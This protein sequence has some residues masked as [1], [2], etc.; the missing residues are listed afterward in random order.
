MNYKEMIAL[1]P[2]IENKKLKLSA[3]CGALVTCQEAGGVPAYV[4][5][6]SGFDMQV[7]VALGG[8]ET[9]LLVSTPETAKQATEIVET[10]LHSGV[11]N[12]LVV[13]GLHVAAWDEKAARSGTSLCCIV[14]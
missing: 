3:V 7:F 8:D 13:A 14:H 11:V 4:D 9:R 5:V 12:L 2:G 10:L 1:I 6:E